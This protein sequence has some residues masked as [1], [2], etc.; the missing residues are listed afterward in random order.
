MGGQLYFL[1]DREDKVFNIFRYNPADGSLVK[2]SD[3]TVWDIRRFDAHGGAIV[4][5][6]G[7]QL[8]RLDPTT[9]TVAPLAIRSEEHTSELPSLMRTSYDV[10][11]LKKKNTI[12]KK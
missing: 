3:E 1:S 4:Y 7:G 9:G 5:E 11:C 12:I 10:F 8:K 6:A 2:V